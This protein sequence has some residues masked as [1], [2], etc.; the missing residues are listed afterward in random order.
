MD[1]DSQATNWSVLILC[2][3]FG[4]EMLR[5]FVRITVQDLGFDAHVYD[6]PD[7]PVDSTIH[8]HSAC[9]NAISAHDIV[10]AFADETEGGEFQVANAPQAMLEELQERE[11]IPPPGSS[12]PLPTIFQVEVMTA[13]SLGKPT[14]VFIGKDMKAQI[15]QI[16]TL[17]RQ[18]QLDVRPRSTSPP[19]LE[20][21]ILAAKWDEIQGHFEVPA[22]RIKSFRQIAF[23][24]RVRKETPNFIS[25][26]DTGNQ[27]TFADEIRSRL[28]GV[29]ETFIKEH[30]AFV[31]DKIQ[32]KRDPLRTE[33]LQD[34]INL[35]LIITSP[36]KLLSGEISPPLF[37]NEN[38]KGEIANSLIALRD[39]LLLGRPGLGKTT[40]S[41]LTFRDLAEHA[42]SQVEGLA[43][44]YAGWRTLT[45]LHM[46]N[47]KNVGTVAD[48][49]RLLIGLPRGRP[50]WPSALRLPSKKWILVLDGLDES[51]LDR[52]SLVTLIKVIS[53]GATVLLSCREYDYERYLETVKHQFNLVIQ[54]LPWEDQ[55]VRQ[56]L[57]ALK[58]GGKQK[59][60]DFI[61]NYLDRKELPDF[62][63]LPL[64]L[65]VL[66]YL[67]ERSPAEQSVDMRDRN[68]YELLR[69][70][71]DAVA[72]D[73]LERQHALGKS[74]EDLRSLL[75][76]SAWELQKARRE[77]S[78]LRIPELERLLAVEESAPVGRAV[79]ALLDTL[80]DRVFGF[81]H[82]VFQEYWLAEFLVD[83]L[84]DTN[85]D[86]K[87]RAEY[88][89]YQR[90]VVTNRF[91]RLRIK[92]SEDV[93]LISARLQEAIGTTDAVAQRAL[94]A[95]NQLVYLL[96]R[97]DEG[98]ENQSFL[99]SIWNSSSESQ[100]VKHSAAFGAIMLGDARIETEYYNLLSTSPNDDEMNR[101]Y[102]LYYYGDIDA[103]E[104]AMPI[105]DPGQGDA[106][107]TLRRLFTRL[108][109]SERRYLNLRRI[110][111]FTMRRF[112]ETKRPVP[113]DI[114]DP[115]GI[116]QRAVADARTHALSDEYVEGVEKEAGLVLALLPG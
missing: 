31:N 50:P 23:L 86:A 105:V 102:H 96:G 5:S 108:S 79:F 93:P 21:L 92:S 44:L 48:F 42:R 110:E 36:F 69:L 59:A 18:N 85:V 37:S 47:A 113:S 74:T 94:F 52:A 1:K 16:I 20:D 98:A 25:Y 78:T 81:F 45:D 76:L 53:E 43:P 91:V 22:G 68:D 30:I 7:Y 39:V 11:I 40:A 87:Q 51:P 60:F 67:A 83:R 29:A 61:G 12:A 15:D 4:N 73:E 70:C 116:V 14:I 41:L 58:A 109:R 64:W 33:S 6:A 34:L 82:Q 106:E 32:R 80:G 99:S 24:E 10:L 49:I 28:S 88:F 114:S 56:Y 46:G 84:V 17:L 90:S 95:K 8:S 55:H 97:I 54:L 65:S 27:E 26:Y 100:F 107:L 9:V 77:R 103:P 2:T 57:V 75:E 63:S 72:E 101:G 111:M 115:R 89:S 62:I 19:N 66:T 104:R 71:A 13:R 38:D 112:L 3:G 35:R